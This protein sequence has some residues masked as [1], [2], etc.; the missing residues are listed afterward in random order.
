MNSEHDRLLYR[1]K[2]AAYMLD[3]SR[4]QMYTLINSGLVHTVKV[5]NSIRIPAEE[6]RK[7]GAAGACFSGDLEQKSVPQDE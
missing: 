4:S 1:V 6:L 3:V 7:I 2:T 5:G